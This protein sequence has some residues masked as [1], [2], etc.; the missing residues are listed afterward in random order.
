MILDAIHYTNGA[1]TIVDDAAIRASLE[2]LA[3][4]GIYVEPTS[5]VVVK[6][7]EK[8]RDAGIIGA[9]RSDSIHSHRHRFENETCPDERRT[10]PVG[11]VC[12]RASASLRAWK[13]RLP[14]CDASP[15]V[16]AVFNFRGRRGF[17]PASA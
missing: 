17:Q 5:A 10:N 6:A 2:M 15:R 9:R 7:Y 12:N 11:A 3:T 8:F 16:G 13:A 4:R 1:F 14:N